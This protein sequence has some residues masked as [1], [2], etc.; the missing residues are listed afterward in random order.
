MKPENEAFTTKREGRMLLSREKLQSSVESYESEN[1]CNNISSVP[2]S[3]TKSLKARILQSAS[4]QKI[5]REQF[6]GLPLRTVDPVKFDVGPR[7]PRSPR[8]PRR[9]RKTPSP[10][11]SARRQEVGVAVVQILELESEIVR[12]LCI[13]GKVKEA[14]HSVQNLVKA[15][16]LIVE[17]AA[18]W[19]LVLEVE[20]MDARRSATSVLMALEHLCGGEQREY[21]EPTL[22][23]YLAENGTTQ[24]ANVIDFFD[25]EEPEKRRLSFRAEEA[26]ELPISIDL[27]DD[28]YQSDEVEAAISTAP[29]V[30]GASCGL[31]SN[32]LRPQPSPTFLQYEEDTS[33]FSLTALLK[34]LPKPKSINELPFGAKNGGE[35]PGRDGRNFAAI[36]GSPP[37][38]VTMQR[39]LL[40]SPCSRVPKDE[41]EVNDELEDDMHS[42]CKARLESRSPARHKSQ[43]FLFTRQ[44]EHSQGSVIVL[45]PVRQ[46][47]TPD[48]RIATPVRR[49]SRVSVT[50]AEVKNKNALREAKYSYHPNQALLDHF[51]MSI[52]TSIE[53]CTSPEH[54]I[55]V[56]EDGGRRSARKKTP[57]KRLDP[58][59]KGRSYN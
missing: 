43:P 47:N 18:F 55:P 59:M 38:R 15:A 32:S 41:S 19:Q 49:S 33:K 24:P 7:S 25:H 52:T 45:S 2:V 40:S 21:F 11:K 26:E 36:L 56:A 5:A 31:I 1:R 4:K 54:H 17:L 22:R 9:V 8:S 39:T 20:K 16:P 44:Q 23:Q 35:T 10:S 57:V 58:K 34:E 30:Q 13:Q 37:L 46:R 48:K 12:R 6:D 29:T 42:Q 53:A 51:S 3:N 27:E 28:S 14:R 50:S